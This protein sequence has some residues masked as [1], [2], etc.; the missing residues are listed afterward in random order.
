[1]SV[2]NK[3]SLARMADRFMLLYVLFDAVD[4]GELVLA[5]GT[6]MRRRASIRRVV[7]LMKRASQRRRAEDELHD[8]LVRLDGEQAY[9]SEAWAD[10]AAR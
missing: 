2:S 3:T 1:M 4:R 9:E 10:G 5:K 7:K 6:S 8:L